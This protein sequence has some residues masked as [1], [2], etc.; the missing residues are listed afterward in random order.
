[1]EEKRNKV[2]FVANHKGFSKF[3]APYM[4]WFRDQGWQ[5]D[6]ASP[7]IMVD[8]IDNHYDIPI[9]RSPISL[10]NFTAY[11]KLKHLIERNNYDLIHVHTPMG[12]VIGRLAARSARKKGTKVIYTAHGFHFYKGAPIRNWL[13]YYPIE[14][15]QSSMMDAI[16]TINEEDYQLAKNHHMAKDN[17]FKIDG[18]GV[19]LDRFAPISIEIR[20]EI[21]KTLDIAPDD[22]VCLYTAQ[23]I[24]SKNHLWILAQL[25]ILKLKVPNIKIIFAGGGPMEEVCKQYCSNLN[26]AGNIR[27]LGFRNDIPN[28]CG[29]ADIHISAS[30]REGQ[31]INNI[32]AMA[33]GC[34]LVISN[35][36]G[37]KDVC[38]DKVNGF[39][40]DLNNPDKFVEAVTLLA[41]N[42]DLRDSISKQNVIDAN[43]FSIRREVNEMAKIYNSII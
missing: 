8:C 21:R 1:M 33:C 24:K 35:I 38:K 4:Q 5:V 14:M 25:P 23:F 16:I 28:L 11:R 34:P 37:H 17:V 13:L 43:K 31:G 9:Q 19:N 42:I 10:G 27:F 40:F 6:N 41:E 2:L 22:F 39:L 36:R 26:L 7:G 18:V 32:E 30:E 12:A 20:N 15:L 3:N 29:M